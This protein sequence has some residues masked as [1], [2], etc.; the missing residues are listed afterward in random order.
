MALLVFI[1]DQSED[2]YVA[3]RLIEWFTLAPEWAVLLSISISLV[4]HLV[5]LIPSVF[6][7][8][9]NVFVWGPLWGGLL[10]LLGEVLGSW[11]AF[12]I[13][14]LGVQAIDH[15]KQSQWKWIRIMHG[16]RPT[17]L[18]LSV[19]VGRLIPFIPSIVINMF[20]A[21]TKIHQV[22][23]F[24]A[25]LLGKIPAMVLE[26]FISYDLIHIQ[27]NYLRLIVVLLLIFVGYV[28]FHWRKSNKS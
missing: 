9:A 12:L 6:I 11:I 1:L 17:Q 2:V 19:L 7:T 26:V 18:F 24:L 28:L 22:H 5:G 15:N 4:I 25:T 27:Q 14:R 8:T 16:W 23:F 21:A 13:Y 10:S 3:Q 20:A